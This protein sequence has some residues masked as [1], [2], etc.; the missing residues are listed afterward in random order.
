MARITGHLDSLVW[1]ALNHG[2]GIIHCSEIPCALEHTPSGH[3]GHAHTR[4]CTVLL[5]SETW[6]HPQH[7]ATQSESRAGRNGSLGSRVCCPRVLPWTP[8]IPE[9]PCLAPTHPHPKR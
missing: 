3:Q 2:T 9:V 6:L 8:R 1:L 4:T 5:R 7:W